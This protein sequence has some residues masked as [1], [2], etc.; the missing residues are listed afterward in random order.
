MRGR[1]QDDIH[2][3][4]LEKW[5]KSLEKSSKD[6]VNDVKNNVRC[7]C[8]HEDQ[9]MSLILLTLEDLAKTERKYLKKRQKYV[10]N[11]Q[12]KQLVTTDQ[13]C[14]YRFWGHIKAADAISKAVTKC[15]N[16]KSEIK[17]ESEM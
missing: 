9:S 7:L 11:C 14:V 10:R 5:L 15:L 1:E 2:D 3:V 8:L 6:S 16:E 13:A 4:S 12:D 17:E